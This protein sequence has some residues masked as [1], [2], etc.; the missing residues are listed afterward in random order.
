MRRARRE[1]QVAEYGQAETGSRRGPIDRGQQGLAHT[2]Q[3]RYRHVQV[4]RQVLEQSAGTLARGR[5]IRDIAAR[6]EHTPGTRE[7]HAPNG[8][9]F[10]THDGALHER[11]RQLQVDGVSRFR[12][13]EGQRRNRSRTGKQDCVALAER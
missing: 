9:V 2:R 13:V 6:A 3:P 7:H 8:F 12:P 5:K 10:V 1:R 4:R 11:T